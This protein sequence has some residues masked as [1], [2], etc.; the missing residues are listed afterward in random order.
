MLYALS[1]VYLQNWVIFFG[2]M[3]VN[4]PYIEHMGDVIITLP[5]L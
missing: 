1:M 5:I 3:L 4:I 2:Q